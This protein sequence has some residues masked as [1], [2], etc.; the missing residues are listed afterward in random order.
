MKGFLSYI[1]SDDGQQAAAEQAGSAPLDAD[2]AKKS[3]AIVATIG[4]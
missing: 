2:L 3:Q 1:V 4:S